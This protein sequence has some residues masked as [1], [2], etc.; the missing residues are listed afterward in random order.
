MRLD[1]LS[2]CVDKDGNLQGIQ[3]QLYSPKTNETLPLNSLGTID[4]CYEVRIQGKPLALEFS[5]TE[6]RGID[7]LVLKVDLNVQMFGKIN[8][9][10]FYQKF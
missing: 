6:K 3:L 7:A 2:V 4:Q 1:S 8:I 5:K 10:T 9:E